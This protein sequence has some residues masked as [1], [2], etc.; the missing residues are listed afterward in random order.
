MKPFALAAVLAVAAPAVAAPSPAPSPP[1]LQMASQKLRDNF[2]LLTGP[3]GNI[4]LVVGPD[5]VYLIDDQLQPLTP[6][7]KAEIAK[8]TDKPVRFVVNTHWHRDHT[9]GNQAFGEAGAVILA[10]DNV[11]KRLASE[12]FIAA[13]NRRVPPSPPS[14]LPLI[15]FADSLT[16]HLNGDDVEVLHVEPAHTDGDSIVRFHKADVIHMGDTLMTMGYPFVD[17]SSGGRFDGFIAAAERALALAGPQTRIIPG[18]G[19]A[20]DRAGLVQWRDMLRTIRERVAKAVAD[21]K[22]L[23]EVQAA[24][25]SA[26]WDARLGKGFITPDVLVKSLYEELTTKR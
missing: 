15:T 21:K 12:Q 11:R 9:G 19:P 16:L 1:P 10:H 24:H 14:G 6:K 22:S 3:G 26:E 20:T 7:L 4:A 5:A 17:R 18:H 13:L 25:P 2:W 23:A 8:V